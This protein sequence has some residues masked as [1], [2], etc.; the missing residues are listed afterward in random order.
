MQRLEFANGAEVRF[1]R[2]HRY[3]AGSGVAAGDVRRMRKEQGVRVEMMMGQGGVIF[4]ESQPRGQR[5]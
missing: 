5:A 2:G 4:Y 1:D 3:Q